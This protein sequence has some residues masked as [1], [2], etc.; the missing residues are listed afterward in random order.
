[1]NKIENIVKILTA[2]FDILHF[3]DNPYEELV[4]KNREL[5]DK[6]NKKDKEYGKIPVNCQICEF[7]LEDD[8]EFI[9]EFK[10]KFVCGFDD[11]ITPKFSEY[12]DVFEIGKWHL[13]E[14]LRRLSGEKK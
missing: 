1:M 14:F 3:S 9:K 5:L 12:C 11:E 7:F 2:I 6:L 8:D 10:T 4:K 13:V